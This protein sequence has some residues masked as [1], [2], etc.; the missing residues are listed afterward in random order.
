M[1]VA[2][3]FKNFS[4]VCQFMSIPYAEEDCRFEGNIKVGWC[5]QHVFPGERA[6]DKEWSTKKEMKTNIGP[7]NLNVN[8]RSIFRSLKVFLK[9][10]APFFSSFSSLFAIILCKRAIKL[11][12]VDR[13]RDP[14]LKYN[15]QPNL[16]SSFTIQRKTLSLLCL[17]V[18]F[19]NV[20]RHK[21][22]Y[23]P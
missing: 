17:C 6:R 23:I 2:A 7:N 4:P 9:W 1:S 5:S 19:L 14:I 21:S 3:A 10:C 13:Q 8:A 11:Y 22:L 15:F 20:D 18:F 12:K 16:F